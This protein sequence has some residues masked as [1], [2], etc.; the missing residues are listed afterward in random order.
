MIGVYFVVALAAGRLVAIA[1]WRKD[2][3]DEVIRRSNATQ[4][5][6]GS[7]PR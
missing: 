6:E 3:R 4:S 2:Q 5:G 1:E 7:V